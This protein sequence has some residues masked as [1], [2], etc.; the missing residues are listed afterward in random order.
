MN[1]CK[2]PKC[3][4]VSCCPYENCDGGCVQEKMIIENGKYILKVPEFVFEQS[5]EFAQS[6]ALRVFTDFWRFH[7]YKK[8]N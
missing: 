7:N 4:S 6:Q 5:L 2:D 3:I 8:D 1:C